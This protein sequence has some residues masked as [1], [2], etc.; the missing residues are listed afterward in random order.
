MSESIT[1]PDNFP[2]WQRAKCPL[3]HEMVP[4]MIVTW[5]SLLKKETLEKIKKKSIE[6]LLDHA[7]KGHHLTKKEAH[8][9]ILADNDWSEN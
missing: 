5:A 4:V 9:I 6:T 3:C 8:Q 1:I 7:Q 2:F